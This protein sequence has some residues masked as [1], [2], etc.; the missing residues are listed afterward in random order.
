MANDHAMRCEGVISSAFEVSNATVK[1]CSETKG[2]YYDSFDAMGYVG[3]AKRW[4]YHASRRLDKN[5]LPEQRVIFAQKPATPGRKQQFTI[6]RADDFSLSPEKPIL[7]CVHMSKVKHVV[8]G[9]E[10]HR[11]CFEHIVTDQDPA[12]FVGGEL[13]GALTT[14][15]GASYPL[16][17]ARM[18]FNEWTISRSML[19]RARLGVAGDSFSD[20]INGFSL[21]IVAISA[22]SATVDVTFA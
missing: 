4:R 12:A 15:P 5:V 1:T 2:E 20:A 6:Y 22:A 17:L 21:K 18:A 9:N 13:A 19:F 7:L 11:Y 14:S 10:F 8:A 16:V 3:D